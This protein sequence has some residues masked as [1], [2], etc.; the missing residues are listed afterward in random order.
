MLP[1]VSEEL[2]KDTVGPASGAAVK[3]VKVPKEITLPMLPFQKEGLSWM[4]QQEAT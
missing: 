2:S 3:E 1:A 4:C